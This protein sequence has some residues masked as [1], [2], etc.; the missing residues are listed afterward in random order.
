MPLL[1]QMP[2]SKYAGLDEIKSAVSSRV[3]SLVCLMF[4]ILV[5]RLTSLLLYALLNGMRAPN[6][7]RLIPSEERYIGSTIP[8]ISNNIN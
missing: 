8:D 6:D 1:L 4:L 7:S 3:G 5:W 2:C